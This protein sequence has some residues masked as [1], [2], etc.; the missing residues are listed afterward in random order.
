[1]RYF[2]YFV[3]GIPAFATF[4]MALDEIKK[5]IEN[6]N[7]SPEIRNKNIY[8]RAIYMLLYS[9]FESFFKYNMSSA[10]NID[11]KRKEYILSRDWEFFFEKN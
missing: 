5:N 3:S 6:I 2:D 11:V 9:E 1:M 4:S 10:I 8:M 7:A